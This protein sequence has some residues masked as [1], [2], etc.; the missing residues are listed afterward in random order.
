MEGRSPQA[1]FCSESC[2]GKNSRRRPPPV[3]KE[4]SAPIGDRHGNARF[5]SPTC[6]KKH[7]DAAYY[8][9][10]RDRVLAANAE[11]R[12]N[13]PDAIRENNARYYRDVI[14][15]SPEILA[16]RKSY[17]RDYYTLNR[18]SIR[19]YGAWYRATYPDKW[20]A[21]NAAWIAA[22]PDKRRDYRARRRALET[23]AYV[24]DVDRSHVWR[25][26]H[27]VCYLC[28][29]PANE[30]DWH[31]DHIIPLCGGGTHSYD[32]VAVTH[33]SCNQSKG[34]KLWPDVSFNL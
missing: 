16:A 12:A 8:V 2:R 27:G 1:R 33:P 4:C 25:R 34:G 3:C 19:A 6:A 5:C 17:S 26:D 11:W 18:E 32:N 23:A 29:L 14:K 7:K 28:G 9:R 15:A 13:N 30:S 20:R 24:E 22:N 10:H 21:K 31:L